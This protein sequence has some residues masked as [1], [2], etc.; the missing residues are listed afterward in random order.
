[1]AASARVD[2]V[3]LNEIIRAQQLRGSTQQSVKEVTLTDIN[4]FINST[5]T[6]LVTIHTTIVEAP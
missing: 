1:L 3:S 6:L 5:L 2:L 4:P